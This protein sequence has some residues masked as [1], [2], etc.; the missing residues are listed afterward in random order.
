MPRLTHPST[1][2][3]E[4]PPVVAPPAPTE[5]A[6]DATRRLIGVGESGLAHVDVN[7]RLIELADRLRR[8]DGGS[9]GK[10]SSRQIRK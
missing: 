6:V 8:P 2:S 7:R 1:G 3:M 5:L 4:D 10:D 9:K